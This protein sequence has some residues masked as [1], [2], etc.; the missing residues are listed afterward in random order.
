MRKPYLCSPKTNRLTEAVKAEKAKK[1]FKKFS[2]KLAESKSR[3]TFA[4][5]NDGG[6]ANAT[7]LPQCA[8]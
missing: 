7:H 2:E 5:P 3:R 1:F 4:L 8:A 6:L